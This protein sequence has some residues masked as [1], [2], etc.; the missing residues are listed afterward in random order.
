M[1]STNVPS[2]VDIRTDPENFQGAEKQAGAVHDAVVTRRVLFV[3]ARLDHEPVSGHGQARA[4]AHFQAQAGPVLRLIQGAADAAAG[5]QP[6]AAHVWL[7]SEVQELGP[8]LA[9]GTARAAAS[10]EKRQRRLAWRGQKIR[11]P[12]ARDV[13]RITP[14]VSGA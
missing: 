12:M 10:V 1:I 11:L 8:L 7:S 14:E 2:R 9:D 5:A 13:S 6:C 4:A 3:E